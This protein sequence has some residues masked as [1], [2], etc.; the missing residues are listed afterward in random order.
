MNCCE[1]SHACSVIR[2]TFSKSNETDSIQTDSLISQPTNSMR[3]SRSWET[4]SCSASQET[5]R[6]LWKQ[7]PLVPI[8]SHMIQ[9]K[10]SYT[11]S[12]RSAVVL[13]TDLRLGPPSD[14][15]PS[16]FPTEILYAFLC[17]P[18]VF[19]ASVNP[20]FFG[21]VTLIFGEKYE[22]WRSSLCNS[23]QFHFT[24]SLLGANIF[25]S[26][27]FSKTFTLWNKSNTN[28]TV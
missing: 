4:N 26:T 24:S 3:Q 7:Q 11:I 22:L 16:S 8:L 25:L 14:F 18:Y 13:S 1:M 27:L 5:P 19:H 15:F 6:L 9:S 10:L 20:S 17:H 28:M 23:S 12:L 21:L 2:S